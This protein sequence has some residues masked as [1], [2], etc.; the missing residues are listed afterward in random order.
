MI[1]EVVSL[2]Q[3]EVDGRA[4]TWKIAELPSAECD[5]I[6]IKQ[7]FQ[8]L[9][10]NALKFTRTRE[11]AVIEISRQQENGR[12]SSRFATTASAST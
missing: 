4:V 8:N 12:T 5:P 11:R 7:V 9:L 3:P 2:L 10:A 6:L 1:E